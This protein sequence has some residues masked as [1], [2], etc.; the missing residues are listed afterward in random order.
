[1]RVVFILLFFVFVAAV[2]TPVVITA[3]YWM[4]A[5][6]QVGRAS[7]SS[8]LL[9]ASETKPLSIA[10]RVIAADQ[11][12]QTWGANAAPCRTMSL[13]WTDFTDADARPP[14]MPASQRA[15]ITLLGDRRNASARWQMRRL[16][17]ACQL[18]QR[19]NDA[20][21]LRVWLGKVNFGANA[22]GLDNA[23]RANFSKP[24]EALDVM[25][26]A[27]LAALLHEA[28]LRSQPDRWN[29]EAQRLL[30][31]ITPAATR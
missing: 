6:D 8:A 1:M 22:I 23:A 31:R 15:A 10:E 13:L 30:Q 4:D 25:E 14:S 27:K 5:G 29:S 26:S 24:A 19:F 21:L 20:Q 11:F 9:P 12:S 18:E 17:V 3:N 16:L 7:Q 28:G 2:I